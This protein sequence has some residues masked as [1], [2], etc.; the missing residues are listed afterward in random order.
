MFLEVLLW[1]AIPLG[2]DRFMPTPPDNPL[3][4]ESIALGRQLFND[5]RLSRDGTL[6]CASCHRPDQAFAD[7]RVVPIGI[8]RRQGRRNSPAIIN[9]AY[10]RSFF[11]DGRASTLESLVLRPISDAAELGSSLD[12]A[13]ARTQ[14]PLETM[15]RA[16]ASY[17]RSILAGD[18]PYDRYV[19]GDESA[20]SAQEQRGLRMFRGRGNCIA[21]HVGPTL[22]DEAFHNTGVAWRNGAFYDVGRFAIT[23]RDSDRGSFKTPT[24]REI[25]RTAPYMHDGSMPTLNDVI[26][27]YDRGGRSNQFLDSE[28]KPLGLTLAEKESLAAFLRALSGKIVEGGGG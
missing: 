27:F 2:L 6:S 24:L 9:R 21:C 10:G 8:D 12:E 1:L 20:L 11:W 14:V 7:G 18:S 28:I 19:N 5:T 26:E 25:A 4:A 17:V 23:Q 16:L 3:T 15:S 13:A 22:S